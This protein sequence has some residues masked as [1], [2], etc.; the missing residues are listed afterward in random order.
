MVWAKPILNKKVDNNAKYIAVASLIGYMGLQLAIWTLREAIFGDNPE[1]GDLERKIKEQWLVQMLTRSGILGLGDP[2]F[3]LFYSGIK[4]DADPTKLAAGTIPGYVLEKL[5]RIVFSMASDDNSENTLTAERKA[6]KS[7]YDLL[8][9]VA[10]YM[11]MSH[12]MLAPFAPTVASIVGSPKVRNEISRQV[13]PPTESEEKYQDMKRRSRERD[14][15]LRE[16]GI[17]PDAPGV[18][19]ANPPEPSTKFPPKSSKKSKAGGMSGGKGMSG[20]GMGSGSGMS[21]GKGM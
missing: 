13:L 1:D 21:A 5:G 16:R 8:G 18:R 3:N 6:F 9:A 19:R 4:Y 11:S 7:G 12:P 14:D 2:F 15:K 17:D 20:S 10:L